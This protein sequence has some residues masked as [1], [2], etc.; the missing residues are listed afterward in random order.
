MDDRPLTF[1]TFTQTTN[2]K[3]KDMET[4]VEIQE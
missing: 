4:Q 1:N 3:F 2:S